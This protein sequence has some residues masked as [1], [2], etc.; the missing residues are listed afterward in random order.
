[1]KRI[2][3]ADKRELRRELCL[4]FDGRCAYCNRHVGMKG[5]VDHYMPQSLGGTNARANLR[6]SC[7]RCNNAKDNM[8]PDEWERCRPPAVPTP[9]T[10]YALRCQLLQRIAARSLGQRHHARNAEAH[11]P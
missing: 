3:S 2:N 4:Q 8:H 6:W 10:R 5:T 7:A 9:S 11:A 1:M